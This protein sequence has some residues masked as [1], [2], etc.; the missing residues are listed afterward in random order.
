MAVS[1]VQTAEANMSEVNSLLRD[2]RQLT[3]HALNDGINDENMLAADQ[4]E[5]ENT[6]E[7]I[8]GIANSAQFGSLKLLDGSTGISGTT[9]GEH[10]E[11]VGANMK[12]G[13]SRERG[14]DV[15]I[16]EEATKSTV[17][18]QAALTQ[19]I[20][21]K[22]ETITVFEDNQKITFVTGP[23]DTAELVAQK[24]QSKLDKFGMEIESTID[25]AGRL[26]LEHKKWGS[27]HFFHATSS[28][29]GVLSEKAGEAQNCVRGKDIKGTLNGE[30]AVGEGQILS[31]VKGA[32]CV[33]GLSVRFHGRIKEELDPECQ[34][35]LDGVEEVPDPQL[36][37]IGEQGISV[38]RVFVTQNSMKF[39]IGGNNR[40]TAS[41]SVNNVNTDSLGKGI[42]NI[43]GYDCLSDI[44]VTTFQGAQDA[45]TLIDSALNRLM[46]SR[47][48]LGSFQ[49]N[50]LESNL[51]NIRIANENLTS[52]NSVIRDTDM[53]KEMANYTRSQILRD[54]S[55]A[56]LAQANQIPQKVMQL[57]G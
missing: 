2:I 9:V 49:K 53:A 33:E 51:S 38:G 55:S 48:S 7:A 20:I 13:D 26:K 43:S 21:D 32:K 3:L 36:E 42:D 45:L 18:G 10:L 8:N 24:L 28:T 14:F 12:T 25:D 40:Q 44:D 27:K 50:T 31:G 56:M 5:I 22:R 19:E 15:R 17:T 35:R 57:L 11:F 23:E 6:L 41:L 4:N 16:T 37:P 30:A 52:T 1:M 54:S 47:G 46:T 29:A 39:Q 34:I